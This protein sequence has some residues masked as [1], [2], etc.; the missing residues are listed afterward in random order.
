MRSLVSYVALVLLACTG[1]GLAANPDHGS[2]LAQRWCTAC[3]VVSD[4]QVKGTDSAPSF[5]SI[6][7]RPDFDAKQVADFLLQPHPKME[8]MS[9]SRDDANDLSAYIA[10]KRY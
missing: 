7:E 5:A 10:G 9:L 1:V 3:H 2:T 6:A 8:T 4:D